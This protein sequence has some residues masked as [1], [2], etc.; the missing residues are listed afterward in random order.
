LNLHDLVFAEE[1]DELEDGT[2]LEIFET[3][4]KLNDKV[5]RHAKVKV[6]KSNKP[7]INTES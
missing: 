3:G 4:Y 5:L 1:N 6:S 2:I 7:A